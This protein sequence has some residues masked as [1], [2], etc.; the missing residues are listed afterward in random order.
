MRLIRCPRGGKVA[1][2]NQAVRETSGEIVAFS[3][4]N[5]TW[6]PSALRELVRNFADPEVAYVCGQL[7]LD[8]AD[9]TNREGA[10]WR[11]ELGVRAA[12]SQLALRHRRQR[13]DLRGAPLGLRRRRPA[14]RPRPLVP[15]PD[16]AARPPRGLRTSRRSRSRSRRRTSRTST[17]ARCACSSTAGRSCCEGGMLRGLGP[18]YLTEIVSHRH[19]RYASGLLHLVAARG[20]RGARWARARSTARSSPASSRSSASLRCGPACRATTCS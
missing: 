17:G 19:L 11:Y 2:Q 8:D 1:A 16:G 18:L 9:G 3:D 5:A 20:E 6:A 13:L 12:E 10:Y 14:V 7:R 15:V 4:A